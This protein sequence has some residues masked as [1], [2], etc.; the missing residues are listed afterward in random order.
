MDKISVAIDEALRGAGVGAEAIETVILTGG[1]AQVPLV[2]QVATS[3]LPNARD[4]PVRSIRF[5]RSGS[6]H[7]RGAPLRPDRVCAKR[8]GNPHSRCQT[9]RM[10]GSRS[11]LREPSVSSAA[12]KPRP[13]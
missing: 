7:R 1:G 12:T 2:R 9:Y 4:R 13:S 8:P 3:R 6:R 10:S 5:G 11:S